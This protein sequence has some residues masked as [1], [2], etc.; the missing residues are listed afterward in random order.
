MCSW[1][2]SCAEQVEKFR[3]VRVNVICELS[4]DENNPKDHPN[5]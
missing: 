2:G 5:L 1:G 4:P 3:S